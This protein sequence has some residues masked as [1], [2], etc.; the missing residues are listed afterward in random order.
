MLFVDIV[1][2]YHSTQSKQKPNQRNLKRTVIISC[3]VFIENFGGS[4]CL[5]RARSVPGAF[6]TP[7]LKES[8]GNHCQI[9]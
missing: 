4:Q 7:G 3:F 6:S 1:L 5:P 9:W 2:T 8:K